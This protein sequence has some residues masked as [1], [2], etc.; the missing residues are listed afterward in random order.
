MP[1]AFRLSSVFLP[2]EL[3]HRVTTRACSGRCILTIPLF[4]DGFDGGWNE[5]LEEG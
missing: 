5:L 3:I 2:I 4:V 1:F